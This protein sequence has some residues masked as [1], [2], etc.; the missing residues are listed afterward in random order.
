MIG[1]F[2]RSHYE[3]VLIARVREL[4]PQEEIERRYDA[5]N[6]FEQELV[7]TG[8]RVIKCML[9]ISK[10]EQ[11]ARLA[12]R[13][14]DPTKHWKYNPGDVDERAQVGRLQDGVRGRARTVQHRGA[15]WYVI[16]ADRKWYAQLGDHVLLL[17][18][19]AA[20]DPQW[21][22]RRLRRRGAEGPPRRDL[23]DRAG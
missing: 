10:D 9:H 3:D 5:I 12:G 2:D 7:D 23:T 11:K 21:P 8:G 20:L 13:L 19:L 22:T 1:I 14:E 6:E 17:E 4:A 18:Q 15:P 16:P